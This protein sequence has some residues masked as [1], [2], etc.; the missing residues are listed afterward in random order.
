MAAKP[1]TPAQ[2]AS[3]PTDLPQWSVREGKLHRELRFTDFSAAF[4]FMTRVA[5]AAETL[6]HHPEWCNVWNRVTINLTTHD[7]G[8][9]SNLDVELAQR[10]D[11]L[12]G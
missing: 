3:M 5:L 1:L 11:G 4:G 6:G 7:T 8:G 12:V 9:L 2:I 10:I